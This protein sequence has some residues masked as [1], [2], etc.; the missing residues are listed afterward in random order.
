MLGFGSTFNCVS[1]LVEH[2]S[3]PFL[4]IPDVMDMSF[5]A[6]IDQLLVEFERVESRNAGLAIE[7]ESLRV[8]GAQAEAEFATLTSASA[9]SIRLPLRDL[10]PPPCGGASPCCRLSAPPPPGAAPAARGS[11][12]QTNRRTVSTLALAESVSSSTL[13][14]LAA[15]LAPQHA[16]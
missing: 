10:S 15:A 3:T 16:G 7:I 11:P 9:P 4:Q 5:R 8:G 2:L 6:L 12:R 14:T 1:D 13:R